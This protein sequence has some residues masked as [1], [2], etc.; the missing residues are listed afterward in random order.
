MLLARS[1][2]SSLI[3]DSLRDGRKYVGERKYDKANGRGTYYWPSGEKYEGEFKNDKMHGRG[4]YTWVFISHL[5]Q[6]FA[7]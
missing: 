4:K 5:S 3:I 7:Y 2:H 6:N 1:L